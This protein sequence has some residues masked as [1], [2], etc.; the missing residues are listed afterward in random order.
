M[1]S[2][3]PKLAHIGVVA[4]FIKMMTVAFLGS[5]FPLPLILFFLAHEHP[6]PVLFVVFPFS[7]VVCPALFVVVDSMSFL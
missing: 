2:I 3:I 6:V 5:V 1:L 4:D 7:V